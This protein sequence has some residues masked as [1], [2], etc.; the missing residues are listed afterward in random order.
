MAQLAPSR[1]SMNEAHEQD[2]FNNSC[3]GS[4]VDSPYKLVNLPV[5]D[6]LARTTPRAAST[7]PVTISTTRGVAQP[8]TGRRADGNRSAALNS[9]SVGAAPSCC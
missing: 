3:F 9:H 5:L 7:D 6:V 4:L 1:P 8:L 2:P